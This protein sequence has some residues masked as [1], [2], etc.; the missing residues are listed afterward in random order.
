MEDL[1]YGVMA[2]LYL[3][4]ALSLSLFFYYT[5][6]RHAYKDAQKRLES[7]DWVL[8]RKEWLVPGSLA[9]ALWANKH[10][11]STC[12][13]PSVGGHSTSEVG[14]IYYCN[15]CRPPSVPNPHAN[16]ND[17]PSQA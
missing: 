5:G 14:D 11:C 7:D 9:K 1:F 4:G 17:H 15:T 10:P 2:A 8:A 16:D 6:R 3:G 12:G 13:R